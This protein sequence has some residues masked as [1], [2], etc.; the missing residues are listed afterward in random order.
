MRLLATALAALLYA[1]GWLAGV[2]AV[3]VRWIWSALA[4]GWDDAHR[5]AAR[6]GPRP[7]EQPV[8]VPDWPAERPRDAA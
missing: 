7:A 3:V 4:V 6:T 5:L 8:A 2:V 1:L